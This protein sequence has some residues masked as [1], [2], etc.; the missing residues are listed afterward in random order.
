DRMW[1][2]KAREIVD[3]SMG[4]VPMDAFAQPDHVRRAQVF[5]EDLL[6]IFAGHSR[7][8]LLHLAK[9]AFFGGEQSAASIHVNRAAFEDDAAPAMQRPDL[10]RPNRASHKAANFFV[11]PPVGIFSPSIEAEFDREGFMWGQPPKPALSGAE[12]A[13][14]P[15]KAR[16][17]R[18]HKNASRIP[19]PHA[20]C[21]PAM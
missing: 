4:V 11:M 10:L 14:Q 13:V 17:C 7:V 1:C 9:Q 8:A 5:G 15:G 6:V 16:L 18:C 21:W 12:G 19:H 2:N 3:V 20:V